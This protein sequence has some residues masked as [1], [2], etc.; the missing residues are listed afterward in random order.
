MDK[1]ELKTAGDPVGRT[2]HLPPGSM[3]HSQQMWEKN[4]LCFLWEEG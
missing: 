3:R 1:T 4:P 2:P